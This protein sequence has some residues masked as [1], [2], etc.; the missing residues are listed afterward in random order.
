M[1]EYRNGKHISPSPSPGNRAARKAEK[2]SRTANA[3]GEFCP[4][5]DEDIKPLLTP[6][7]AAAMPLAGRSGEPIPHTLA[8][9]ME[10]L[11]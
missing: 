7:P 2:R 9:R 5:E 3:S 11:L 8:T 10:G 6:G 1:I 4:L